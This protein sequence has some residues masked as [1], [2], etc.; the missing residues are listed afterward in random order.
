MLGI[1]TALLQKT[2]RRRKRAGINLINF[3][4]V[5]LFLVIFYMLTARWMMYQGLS[6][7]VSTKTMGATEGTQT[8]YI[9]V[10]PEAQLRIKDHIIELRELKEYLAHQPNLANSAHV[11]LEKNVRVQTMID[12]LEALNAAGITAT[13]LRE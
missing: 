12:V 4:D 8:L 10:S 11:I 13:S 6:V 9:S 5:L 7:S 1:D 2:D 3:I